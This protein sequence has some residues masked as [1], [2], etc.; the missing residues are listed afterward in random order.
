MGPTS[1]CPG[2]GFRWTWGLVFP[3]TDAGGVFSCGLCTIVSLGQVSASPT[4]ER[5]AGGDDGWWPPPIPPVTLRS[6]P[7]IPL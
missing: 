7:F 4:S 6:I 3:V 5:M 2:L 1:V